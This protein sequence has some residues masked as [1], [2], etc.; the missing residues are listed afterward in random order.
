MD[1]TGINFFPLRSV[2]KLRERQVGTAWKTI[3]KG[4]IEFPSVTY[5]ASTDADLYIQNVGK[6]TTGTDLK[7]KHAMPSADN[8]PSLLHQVYFHYKDK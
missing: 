1:C 7:T 2:K 3:S 4:E 6:R 5:C 8:Q